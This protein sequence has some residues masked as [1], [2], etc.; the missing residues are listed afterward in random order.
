MNS[1]LRAQAVLRGVV[2][3]FI[4][5]PQLHA[6]QSEPLDYIYCNIEQVTLW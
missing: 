2:A 6:I 4:Y 3:P 1:S 5:V